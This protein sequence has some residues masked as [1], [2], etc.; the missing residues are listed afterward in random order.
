[1]FVEGIKAKLIPEC[2]D[3]FHVLHCTIDKIYPTIKVTKEISNDYI[4]ID[5]C[6]PQ[7]SLYM[8]IV[9]MRFCEYLKG[10]KHHNEKFATPIDGLPYQFGAVDNKS[11][12]IVVT[13]DLV[14]L[15]TKFTLAARK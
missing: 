7:A 10:I 1:M 15:Q 4:A 11:Y 14:T 8:D 2:E 6:H 5:Y 3:L 13:F 9:V 12:L